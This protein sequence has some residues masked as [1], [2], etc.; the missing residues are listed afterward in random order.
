M[1]FFNKFEIKSRNIPLI[2]INHVFA[3]ML[4]FVPILALYIEQELFS[5]TNVALIFSIQAVL[6]FLV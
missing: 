4:F 3:G 6:H 5:V 1:S 2:Y